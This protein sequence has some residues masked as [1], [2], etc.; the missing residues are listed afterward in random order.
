MNLQTLAKRAVTGVL[1]LT[2]RRIILQLISFITINVILARVLSVSMLGTFNIANT[3]LGFF[4]FFADIG[5]AAALIQKKEQVTRADLTTTFTIQQILAVVLTL[6]IW[7]GAPFFASYYQLTDMGMW[8]VRALA[9]SFLVTTFKVI[10]SVLLERELKFRPLVIV[11]TL[12]AVVFNTALI[13]LVFNN[14]GLM[15]FIIAAV[16]RSVVGVISIYILAPWK[17]GLGFSR[18]ASFQMLS[19]GLPFQLNSLLALAKD[20]LVP[21][22][23]AG[24]VGST[25]VGFITW[26]QNWAFKPLEAM[27]IL[28]RVSF[29]AFSR[30]QDDRELFKRALERSLFL[31]T[32]IV[33][34]AVFGL[35]ALLPQ[36]INLVVSPKWL[37]ALPLFYLFCLSTLWAAISTT[38]T[39][40]LNAVGKVKVTLKLMVMWTVLTWLITPPLTLAFGTLGVG[41]A[42]AIISFTS[43]LTIVA[44]KRV[45]DIAVMQNIWQPLVSSM[46]MGLVV[47]YLA[48][49]YVTNLWQLLLMVIMGASIYSGI[50]LVFAKERLVKEF[51]LIKN[52]LA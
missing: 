46:L 7:V 33:Y 39:N 42:S 41:I 10:P 37:P 14:L 3:I 48:N 40:A 12:E 52:V 44:M 9:L 28:I 23:I 29:P 49:F 30:I 15:A 8:L 38:F 51:L 25:G 19:F 6:V 31:T 34:P 45:V 1:S 32:L 22:V 43:I 20:Y 11:D 50:M 2:T 16:L 18:S 27:N 13:I 47:Y 4:T 26:A 17:M 24:I 21:L 35:A 5:L 36:I